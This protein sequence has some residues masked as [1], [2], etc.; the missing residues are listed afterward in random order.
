MNLSAYAKQIQPQI[1]KKLYKKVAMG[2]IV[3][4][5]SRIGEKV[6]KIP[7]LKPPVYIEEI[8]IKSPLCEI[9][10]EKTA[11]ILQ[12]ITSLDTSLAQ[13]NFL[14]ITCGINE[15]SIVCSSK[16]EQLIQKHFQ[17]K[18]KGFYSDLVALTVRFIE[19]EYLE[20]PNMIYSLISSFAS[21]RI[22]IIE[23]ISTFSEISFVVRKK[24]I[25]QALEV[26]KKH[27]KAN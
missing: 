9:T 15:V 10:Y 20:V 16:I 4:A 5:L 18:P 17:I 12:K 21:Q 6:K 14:T 8:N 2:S 24:E 27:F 26:L 7:P 1:E 25:N 19:Q 3:V 23:I 13:D 11:H 22:N